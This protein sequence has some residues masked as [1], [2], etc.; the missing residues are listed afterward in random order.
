VNKRAYFRTVGY[1]KTDSRKENNSGS[2]FAAILY[3]ELHYLNCW[4]QIITRRAQQSIEQLSLPKRKPVMNEREQTAELVNDSA[5]PSAYWEHKERQGGLSFD[6][7]KRTTADKL[8]HA[9]DTLHQQSERP[10]INENYGYYGQ[11]AADWLERTADYV[12]EL[13]PKQI[14]TD[15]EERVRRNPGRTLLIAGGVGL[16]LGAMLRG[17]R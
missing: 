11:R 12:G 6:R 16:L 9:A 15:L 7:I 3:A 2:R 4:R 8:R 14:R 1:R 5:F 10:E 13:D 17:R